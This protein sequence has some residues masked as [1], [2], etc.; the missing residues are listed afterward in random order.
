M[1]SF[2]VKFVQKDR[3]MDRQM[4]GSKTICPLIFR[5]RGIKMWKKEENASD[6]LILVNS[7]FSPRNQFIFK[8]CLPQASLNVG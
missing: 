8:I 3:Q 5:C 4:D 7:I 6:P 2:Q 1:L